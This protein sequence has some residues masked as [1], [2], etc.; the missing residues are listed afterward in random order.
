MK[1]L[2]RYRLIDNLKGTAIMLGGLTLASIGLPLLFSLLGPD[3]T[4][5][6]SSYTMAGMVFALVVGIVSARTDL[7]LGNQMGLCRRSAFLGSLLG[8]WAAFAIQ[9]ALTTLL[10]L[11]A[12]L[13]SRG[14]ERFIFIELYQTFYGNGSYVMPAAEYLKMT[15][16]NFMGFAALGGFGILCSLAFWRL[17]KLGKWILG[18]GSGLVLIAGIPFLVGKFGYLL[19]RPVRILATNSWAMTAFLL[20]LA[21]AGTGLAWLL[22]RRAPILALGK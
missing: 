5:T 19:L 18:I 13:G 17:G 3:E 4:G 7:R 6:F 14:G 1:T 20:A 22:T 2:L 16:L 11:A 15:L 10:T 21:A 9:S 12:Q 8:S